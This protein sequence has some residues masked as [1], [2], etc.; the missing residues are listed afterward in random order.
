MQTQKHI[1]SIPLFPSYSWW[2]DRGAHFYL[3]GLCVCACVCVCVCVCVYHLWLHP[4]LWTPQAHNPSLFS[5]SPGTVW[6]LCA[7]SSPCRRPACADLSGTACWCAECRDP[8][9]PPD[10]PESGVCQQHK[11]VHKPHKAWMAPILSSKD[12]MKEGRWWRP[13][14]ASKGM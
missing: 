2:G 8:S 7:P 14:G 6:S 10:L 13:Q 11:L 9:C 1:C 12:L 4:F 5:N 3:I